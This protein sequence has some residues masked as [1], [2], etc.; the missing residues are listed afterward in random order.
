MHIAGKRCPNFRV[1]SDFRK[2]RGDFFRSCFKQTVRMALELD[3]ASLG[4]VSLDGS[5]FKANNTA[6]HTENIFLS[7]DFNG[8]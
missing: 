5:K 4:H 7:Q 6:G 3:M 2:D 8:W 1:L